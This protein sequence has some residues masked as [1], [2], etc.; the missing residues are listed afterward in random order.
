VIQVRPWP[1]LRRTLYAGLRDDTPGRAKASAVV[2]APHQDDETLGCGGTMVLKCRAGTAVSCV[3]MT[4]GTTSHRCFMDAEELRNLRMQEAMNAT[5]VLGLSRAN[6]HFLN[7]EDGLLRPS[8]PNAVTQIVAL[9]DRYCPEEIYVPY[10]ADGTADHEA[11]HAVVVEAAIKTG[12]P[13]EICEYPVWVWNQWPWVPLQVRC[14][15]DDGRTLLSIL[16]AG[17]GFRLIRECRSGVFVGD[18]LDQKRE[19]LSQHRSQMT[20][21]RPGTAWP[22]LKDISGGEFLRCF[23]QDFEIFRCW[24]IFG[25]S[26]SRCRV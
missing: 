11:T 21:L 1:Q 19:A 22:T 15:R 25:R 16:R 24:K 20:V 3:F 14:N 6:V 18:L 13:F 10:R 26:N 12:R 7:F 9:L 5:T 8:D 4:D 23:F 17:L 2:F